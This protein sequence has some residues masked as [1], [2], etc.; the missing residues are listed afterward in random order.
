MLFWPKN[1]YVREGT[2]ENPYEPCVTSTY[3]CP[4]LSNVVARA[5]NGDNIYIMANNAQIDYR[6]CDAMSII[7][8]KNLS[9]TGYPHSVVVGCPERVTPVSGGRLQMSSLEGET[10]VTLK[11]LRF[12]N[13]SMDM[14]DINPIVEN[15][16]FESSRFS[17]MVT[18]QTA[19]LKIINTNWLGYTACGQEKCGPTGVLQAKGRFHAIHITNCKLFHTTMQMDLPDIEEIEIRNCE[20]NGQVQGEPVLTGNMIALL[21]LN[22]TTIT[23]RDSVF[24]NNNNYNPIDSVM[25]IFEAGLLI[26]RNGNHPSNL[27]VYVI[28][29]LFDNNERGL[30]FQG[31]ITEVIV[32]NSVFRRNVAMHAGAAVLL[33]TM[34][35]LTMRNCTFDSNEA[36]GFRVTEVRYPGDHFSVYGDEVT[37]YSRCCKGSISLIGKGGAIRVQKG[38]ATL[39]NCHFFNNTARLLGGAIFVDEEGDLTVIDTEFSNSPIGVHS[40]QGDIIYSNGKVN[41]KGGSLLVKTA[42]NHISLLQHSGDHWS[43]AVYEITILCPVGHRLRVVN[44]SAYGVTPNIGLRRSYMLD[45]LSYFC[46][47]CPRHKYSTDRGYL[48]YKLDHGVYEYFTLMIN[49]ENPNTKFDGTYEYFDITC[50]DC[51]YGGQCDKFIRSL[52]N[53]WGYRHNQGIEFQLC[54]KGY[55]CSSRECDSFDRCAVDRTDR[56]CSKCRPGY[57]E[58]L[59]SPLCVPNE[60]CGPFWL[61]PFSF[62]LGLLYMLFLLF[63]KDIR[64]FIFSVP[65]HIGTL[66]QKSPTRKNRKE[67]RDGG[68]KILLNGKPDEDNNCDM[69]TQMESLMETAVVIKQPDSSDTSQPNNTNTEPAPAPAPTPTDYGATILIILL[70]YF[71]DALLF[72]VKTT[73]SG[74]D[75]KRRAQLKTVLLGLFK[76]RLE[77]AHF[78]DNVCLLPDMPPWVKVMVKTVMVPYVLLLFIMLFIV[79]KLIYLCRHRNDGPDAPADPFPAKLATG[80]MLCLLFTYQRLAATAFTLLNCVPIGNDSVLFIDGS[81]VCYQYWQYGVMAYAFCC[82]VPFCM[83]LTL[84][85]GLLKEGLVSLP[86]FFCACIFPLPFVIYW[87]IL[88]L[89]RRNKPIK[90]LD[91]L[92]DETASVC[93]VLQGPFTNINTRFIG[94]TCWAGVLILR[95]LVLV[96]IYTFVNNSLI[97]VLAML[98][99]SFLV[100]LNHVHVQPYKDAPG[101]VAGSLSVA[102]MMVVGGINLVRAGFEAAEYTPQGPNRTLMRVM[103]ETEN[104]LMLWFP[105]CIMCIVFLALGVKIFM[106]IIHKCS[107]QNNTDTASQR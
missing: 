95:R 21:G 51:P 73:D 1:W 94:P 75:N 56:L 84:G 86:T 70:Y 68:E 39:E 97:R 87:V 37:V 32:E 20:F 77:V 45:Q 9:I 82:I 53:F 79:Y 26:R 64:D 17:I 98:F 13:I 48:R 90:E 6:L 41:M 96:L 12:I 59:F 15:C 65:S 100:L 44:T 93:K 40:S 66:R 104:V 60:D 91:N 29:C 11:D 36:G 103:Q 55:C 102:A 28:N 74:G 49:G 23:V 61:W 14:H 25:N 85:P 4:S 107:A 24:R 2:T 31:A 58:A 89:V 72:N 46:E 69:D 38:S 10:H 105:L 30:A 8:N 83:V 78:V 106:M 34:K 81:L 27:T 101:N 5:R 42:N 67:E 80:F 99:F 3:P 18:I 71:Q 35:Q 52:P 57:S 92:S 43:M 47:S 19:N 22:G 88:R 33:L 76:F 62:S 7:I 50:H 63:Q 16:S 54:P